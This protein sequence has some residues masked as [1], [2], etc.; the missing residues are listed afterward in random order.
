MLLKCRRIVSGRKLPNSNRPRPRKPR[1]I[2]GRERGRRR[3]GAENTR[4]RPDT[5]IGSGVEDCA[6]APYHT[7]GRAVFRIRRL[8]AAG[9]FTHG[10]QGPL[11]LLSVLS[12]A[13]PLP[14]PS[15]SHRV[16]RRHRRGDACP[17]ESWPQLPRSA[18]SENCSVCGSSFSLS[19]VLSFFGPSLVRL[20]PVLIATMTSADFRPSLKVRISPGQCCLVPL[21]PSGSTESG[22]M[23]VGLCLC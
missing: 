4:F 14:S 2:R 5:M 18:V 17:A 10:P 13:E 3:G 8:N 19:F 9:C 11:T 16:R 23:T 22:L 20:S 12:R 15:H 6:S 7:T 1:K 21:V